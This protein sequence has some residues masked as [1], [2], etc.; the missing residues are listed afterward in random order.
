MTF[1]IVNRSARH[2]KEMTDQTPYDDGL[3][4]FLR[5]RGVTEENINRMQEENVS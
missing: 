3:W 2:G 5:K 4:D 1:P